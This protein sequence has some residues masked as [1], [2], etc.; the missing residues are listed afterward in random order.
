MICIS[1]P[2]GNGET[3]RGAVGQH[4][5]P[6][7]FS[8]ILVV[9]ATQ[10]STTISYVGDDVQV[11]DLAADNTTVAWSQVGTGYSTVSLTGLLAGSTDDFAHYHNSFY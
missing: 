2:C 11:D 8:T 1:R 10:S 4:L 7:E 6:E 9:P 3:A 5:R